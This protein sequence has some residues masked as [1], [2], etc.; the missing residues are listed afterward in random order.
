VEEKYGSV[1]RE[2]QLLLWK[3]VKI[4]KEFRAKNPKQLDLCLKLL[5]AEHMGF[6]VS[7]SE[8]IKKKIEY[9]II[10]DADEQKICELQEKYRILIS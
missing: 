1:T 2:I 8:N 6:S 10:V 7:V 5:Y 4:M 3:E 9:V